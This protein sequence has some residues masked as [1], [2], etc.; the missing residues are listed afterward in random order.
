M[1]LVASR[2]AA[3]LADPDPAHAAILIYG[4]D[5]VRVADARRTAVAALVGP[6][7]DRDMRLSRLAAADVRGDPALLAD[8]TRAQGL[9]PGPRAVLVEGAADGLSDPL[10]HVL[11][12]WAAGDARIVVTAGH[13]RPSSR[14]RKL[15][16]T[17]ANAAA[18]AIYDDPPGRGTVAAMAREAGIGDVAPEALDDLTALAGAV[19]PVEFRQTLVKIALYKHGD[20]TATGPD[21]V[22]ACA[23]PDTEMAVDAL[24]HLVA[25]G[26]AGRVVAVLRRLESQGV[27]AVAMCIA[28]GRHFRTLHAAASATGGAER[29]WMAIRHAPTRARMQKQARSWPRH[30]LDAAIQLLVETDLALRSSRAAPPMAI[31]ERALI[32][33]AMMARAR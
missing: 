27:G 30:A 19:D 3:Y 18:A 23:P 10:G 17:R 22:A 2:T 26:E 28:C 29:I 32:R 12:G 24:L 20:P 21:D 15:F 7:G 31:L 9:I 1:K 8:A 16:E 6:D 4:M 11:D 14:L 33:L 13:L 25:E 5:P